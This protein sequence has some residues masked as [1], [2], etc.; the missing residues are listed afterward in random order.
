[1]LLH[2]SNTNISGVSVVTS[3]PKFGTEVKKGDKLGFKYSVKNN[4]ISLYLNGKYIAIVWQNIPNSIIPA[5]CNDGKSACY[6][7]KYAEFN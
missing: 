5:A 2:R 3:D 7:I 1:M 4:N 6:T